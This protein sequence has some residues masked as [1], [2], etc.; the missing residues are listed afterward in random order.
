MNGKL[1]KYLIYVLGLP[2]MGFMCMYILRPLTHG[3][4]DGG[5]LGMVFGLI[6]GQVIFSIWL[7]NLRL[8]FSIPLGLLIAAVTIPISYWTI[9]TIREIYNPIRDGGYFREPD[10]QLENILA[11]I[12]FVVLGLTSVILVAGLNLLTGDKIERTKTTE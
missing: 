3:A 7:T 5:F 11:W 8:Y 12:F 4:H 9:M 2:A 1:L 6:V 10:P